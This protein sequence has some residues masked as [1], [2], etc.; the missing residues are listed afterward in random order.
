ME[1]KDYINRID[2]LLLEL[3]GIAAA[4]IAERNRIL[5]EK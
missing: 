2:A 4:M 5:S 3:Q 1:T